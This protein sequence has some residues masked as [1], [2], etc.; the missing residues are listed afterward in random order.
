[1]VKKIL[2]V[3][4]DYPNEIN[5]Y[6]MAYVH[7]RN[8]TYLNK[9]YDIEIS[10]LSFKCKK[11]YI[12]DG[13]KVYSEKEIYEMGVDKFNSFISHAPNVKNHI[14]FFKMN[15]INDITFFIHGHEVLNV[16][17]YYP[18]PYSW[19]KEKNMFLRR[20]YDYFKLKIISRF[21]MSNN[22]FKFIFV[23]KWM[24]NEALKNLKIK[25]LANTFIIHNPINEQFSLKLFDQRNDKKYDF[26]T[27]RPLNG[28][29]YCMDVVY[30]L[31]EKH[32][33]FQFKIIGK[34]DFFKYNRKIDNIDWDNNFYKPNELLKMLNEA[35]VALMPTRLDS[36]GVMMCELATYGMPIITSDIPICYEMLDGYEQSYFINND[37]PELK[38]KEIISNQNFFVPK[39]FDRNILLK[40]FNIEEISQKEL[41]VIVGL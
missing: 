1:M 19:D 14:R 3:V 2:V 29:K 37:N 8:K 10:V 5:A 41:K 15:K 21:F 32:P 16:N 11:S 30:K 36:Q 25:K 38:F 31:A 40:K 35:K 12:W 13:V 17:K 18:K 23:S 27:V 28:A 9:G 34:G 7:T 33:E 4:E 22:D 39:E 24:E 20:I 26:I 6:P